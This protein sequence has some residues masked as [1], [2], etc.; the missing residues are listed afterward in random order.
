MSE[1]ENIYQA[2]EASLREPVQAGEYGSVEKA[3]AGDYELNPI[4]AMKDAWNNLSGMKGSFWG[5][6]AMYVILTMVFEFIGIMIFGTPEAGAFPSGPA[7]LYGVVK[8][9]VLVP[10]S[11]GLMI[12]AIKHSVGA[13]TE[14]TEVFKHFDKIVPLF[15]TS[16][17]M[18]LLVG[19]G[20]LL[21]I[22]PGIYLLIAF[23]MAM[24]LVVE[25]DM[26]PWEAL[27]TSRKAI[28]HNWFSMLGFSVVSFIVMLLGFL[29]FFIGIVWALPLIMLAFATVYRDMFGVE[30]STLAE[31]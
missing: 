20:L 26:G 12:I 14:A 11:I 18:Y 6:M 24:L 16:I 25:K 21:L 19:V 9:I 7:M 27:N 5:G 3:L 8:M 13:R 17:L 1:S 15:V 28:T 30:A 31:S 29:A 2:P 22:I 10:V 4:E 23:S